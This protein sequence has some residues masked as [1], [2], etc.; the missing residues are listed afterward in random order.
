MNA[1]ARLYQIR[2]TGLAPSHDRFGVASS[3][4]AEGA[5]AIQK[6]HAS[7]LHL[8]TPVSLRCARDDEKQSELLTIGIMEQAKLEMGGMDRLKAVLICGPTASRKPALELELKLAQAFG[9]PGL[10]RKTRPPCHTFGTDC[11]ALGAAGVGGR[12]FCASVASTV[13]RVVARIL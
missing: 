7:G 10:R 13:E 5:V 6:P 3:R 9:G 12:Q 11:W 8:L 1:Q 2:L 4:G